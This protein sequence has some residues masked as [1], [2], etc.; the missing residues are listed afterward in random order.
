MMTYERFRSDH[1][2]AYSARSR[3]NSSL[4]FVQEIS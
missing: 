1:L 2:E 4:L 3:L